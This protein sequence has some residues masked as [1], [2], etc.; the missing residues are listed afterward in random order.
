MKKKKHTADTQ[1]IHK[2]QIH[3]KTNQCTVSKYQYTQIQ[4]STNHQYVQYVPIQ[5]IT[6][7]TF[8]Y[9]HANTHLYILIQK[10]TYQYMYNT[11]TIHINTYKYTLPVVP[12]W[13]DLGFFPNSRGYK[14]AA[15]LRPIDPYIQYMPVNTN[16]YNTRWYTSTHSNTGQYPSICTIHTICTIYIPCLQYIQIHTNIYQYGPLNTIHINRYQ[17]KSCIPIHINT[18][19]FRLIRINM[20]NSYQS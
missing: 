10:N 13:C 15:N 7:N 17:H 20:Y 19:Q 16:M 1:E 2:K 12:L 14:A 18:Y 5:T 9:I 11:C 8:R 3:K 6:Y 4:S